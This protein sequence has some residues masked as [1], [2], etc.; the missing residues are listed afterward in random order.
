MSGALTLL[1]TTPLKVVLSETG[2]TSL[3][4][5]DASG[6]FGILPGHADFLTVVGAGVLRWKAGAAPWKYCALRGG[7]M[8]V[9]AGARVA[10][11]CREAI[12]GDDL[13]TLQSKV[14]EARAEVLDRS[15]RTRTQST[16]LHARAIRQLM[17]QLSEGGDT[18]GLLS[19]ADW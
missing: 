3:R 13:E 17:R 19:E 15:R 14:A 9:S 7:V 12:P 2:V 1:V 10:I 5:E 16:R 4:A 18:L 11:A 6:D 8:T